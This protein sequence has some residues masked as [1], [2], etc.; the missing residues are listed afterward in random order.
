MINSAKILLLILSTFIFNFR[1]SSQDLEI[2]SD[3]IFEGEPYLAINPSNSQHIV[4]AWMG[5][6]PFNSISIKSRTSFDGGSTWSSEA[7]IPHEFSGITTTSAD[8]SIEFDD[9]GNVFL[10]YVDYNVLMDSGA[11]FVR[12]ST[13]GGLMWDAPVEVIN[14]HSDG[15]NKPADRPWMRI[16]RS[17]GMNNGNIYVTTMTPRVFGFIPPPYHPYFTRST[18]GGLSFEPWQYL[19]APGWLAGSLIP[20]P[21]PFPTV[22]SNGIFYSVYPS[23]VLT[24]NVNAQYVLAA[25]SDGGNNFTHSLITAPPNSS[26]VTDQ[27]AKRGF[28][29]ISNPSNN[30]HLVFLNLLNTNGDADVFMMETFDGGVNWSNAIRINDDPIGNNRMQDLIW[31]DFDDDGDFI[32]TWRDRRNGTDSTYAT[33]SETWAAVRLKDSANF[34]PNFML[35][36]TIAAY[37]SVLA[38]GGNDFMCVDLRN[39]TI[40]AVWGDTRNGSLSIWYKRLAID[41]TVL[42]VQEVASEKTPQIKLYPNPTASRIFIEGDNLKNVVVFDSNGKKLMSKQIESE[43]QNIE[44]N[45]EGYA[46]GIYIIEVSTLDSKMSKKV[47]KR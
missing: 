24:Q 38:S 46:K 42:S 20:Q 22:T 12:K 14:I 6:V 37:D 17:S 44:L 21:T 8:P 34:M 13:D 2:S 9:L 23:W 1:A 41:G 26:A 33:A 43:G 30:N 35:S 18:N 32:V 7:I 40:H 25:T 36:D 3:L 29:L 16:D 4:V 39:D 31:A 47:I 27:D 19:D 10:C 5:F 11:V 45:L 28:P 15:A